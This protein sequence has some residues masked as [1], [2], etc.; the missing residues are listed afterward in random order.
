ME[1]NVGGRFIIIGIVMVAAVL[2]FQKGLRPGLDIAGGISLIFEVDTT[3]AENDPN[4][5]ENVKKQLQKRLDPQGVYDIAWRVQGRNR[6]EVQMPLPPK[7][8]QQRRLDYQAAIDRLFNRE[9]TR[10]QIE[11]AL[12]LTGAARDETVGKLARGD[13]DAALA[14]PTGKADDVEKRRTDINQVIAARQHLLDTAKT[15]HDAYEAARAALEA[16]QSAAGAN[17][18]S[19]ETAPATQETTAATSAASDKAKLEESLRDAKDL[20]D[21]AVESALATNLN[22]R[23]FQEVL[24]LDAKSPVRAQSL[25][26]T[27]TRH[28]DLGPWIEDVKAKHKTWRSGRQYLDGAADLKRLLRGAG[29]LEFRILAEPGGEN[30]T[31]YDRY[32]DQL[33]KEGRRWAPGD[34][35]GWFKVDNP[36]QFFDKNT[37]EELKRYDTEYQN[38]RRFVVE[39][40]GEDY[41]VL[42]RMGPEYG[43]LQGAQA[44]RKWQLTR[45]RPDVDPR[46]RPNVEFELDVVGG[47][48]FE[49]LTSRN[50][51][52]PLCILVD[53]VAY[54]AP[55][56][57]STIRQRGEITGDFSSEKIEY[58]VQT[59]QGGTLPA[60]LKDTPLS[61]RTIGSSLGEVNRDAAVR[62]G[63]IGALAVILIM[64][65]YYLLCGAIANVAMA[66]NVFLTLAAM[67]MLGA[68]LNLVGIAGIVLSIGMAVDANVLIYERMRE[69]QAR[70][71]SLR[72]II[73]NGYDK[74]FSTIFDSNM[75][76]LLTCLIIYYAGS[77]E[78]KGFGLTLGWGVALNLFTAVF[79]TRAFFAVLLKYNLIKHVQTLKLIGLPKV[80]WCRWSRFFIPLSIVTMIAGIS[81]LFI[82]GKTNVLDI[83]FLGGMNAE[84]ELKEANLNDRSISNLLQRVAGNLVDD[85]RR[86]DQVAVAPVTGEPNT[87][88]VRVP[89]VAPQTL[90]AMLT[91]PLEAERVLQRGG[92]TTGPDHL[93]LQVQPDVT[94]E[95]LADRIRQLAGPLSDDGKKLAGADVNAVLESG[96][97]QEK[98][99]VWNVTTTVTNMRLVEHAL[100]TALGENMRIQPRISYV[101][102]GD[103][104]KPFPVTDRRLVNVVPGLPAAADSDLTNYLGGLAIHLDQLDPP[105]SI[106]DLTARI[107]NALFQP[108]FQNMPKRRFEAF[109]VTP[110]GKGQGEQPLF[111]SVVIVAVEPDVSYKDN[112][113]QWLA[114]VAQPELNLVKTALA[115]GQ[116]LRKVMQ[117]KPQIAARS[118]QQ[119]GVALLLSWAMIIAYVWIRFGR[120]MYGVGGVVALIH[121]VLIAMAFVGFSG[122]IGG[123]THGIGRFF[124]IEDFR[125]NMTIIA[126]LLTIIGFSINDTIVIFDR[127]REMRGRLGLVTPQIINDSINQCMSRTIL[128]TLTVLVVVLIS[129]IFGGSSIRGFN[130]CMLVGCVSGT[131]STVVIAAPL[132]LWRFGRRAEARVG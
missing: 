31:K 94:Q 104:D 11:D 64:L 23:R 12:R 114:D 3:G 13:A 110:A 76:T 66:M 97:V 88:Q 61:E 98:G 49:V 116:T 124:L 127:I 85:A 58:L 7:D 87:F 52:R 45:A 40:F 53:D 70:G 4:L 84:V 60:R 80:D 62:A 78:V 72:M 18:S 16:D 119:A 115:S 69:E 2:S 89:G 129:Y 43:L 50:I 106:A 44:Q 27:L 24:E 111:R 99:T 123:T 25:A 67:A 8:A 105:L 26:D 90:A 101:F 15:R 30:V 120:L 118:Q 14:A 92:L 46:G 132:L 74:A 65:I 81:V 77:E 86:L 55:N 29:R 10:A 35:E 22:R 41:Y 113:K 56:I 39:K 121:D 96:N 71:A 100:T 107:D 42:A 6:I 91:E 122:A 54:S 1:K 95:S 126:A 37:P 20:Y 79:V 5:A 38:D 131:Y 68:R 128:T 48:L 28:A 103:G 51:N 63:Y 82:R 130:Y 102:R 117:F 75:T 125:I 57:Q 21:D 33:K 59:M 32:R 73:K 36:L 93:T 112:P 17:P 83:E 19:P 109:G 9:I 34:P 108:D 47:S